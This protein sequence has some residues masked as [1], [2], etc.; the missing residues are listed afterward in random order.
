MNNALSSFSP[1]YREAREKFLAAAATAGLTVQSHL[2]PLNGRD[3]EALALDVVREG[4]MDAQHLLI[5][6]SGCHGV[7]GY[8]GSGVQVAAL[9]DTTWRRVAR[10][11]GVAV[12]Y[13]HAL[14]PYGF[15]HW[16]R[17]THE[18]VDL[19]RNFHDF[20]K[21]LPINTAYRDV[22]AL[23]LPALWPPTE[24]NQ[25]DVARYIAERGMAA[26]QAAI[27]G[28]QHE[29]ADGLFFGGT[30][31]TWSNLAVREVLRTHATT[32]ARIGW[33]DL[34]TGLGPSGHGERIYA[35]PN[36]A[37]S[38]ERARRW[39]DGDGR[40]PITSTYDG[41]SA[42]AP[43]T[44]IMWNCVYD[45]CPE[46][47]HT[48]IAM[49]Y[50][51]VPLMQVLQALR[52]EQWLQRNPEAPRE[53]HKAIKQQFLDAFYTDTDDWKQA[54]LRQAREAMLQAVQGLSE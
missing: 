40:T 31:P 27:T 3:G 35:G 5:I 19:N 45:E 52:A 26:F 46:S 49:E 9:G 24:E 43:L 13:L 12:L 42:S 14:N 47:Q 48:G 1:S 29:Y 21:P 54:I 17:V 32:A 25:Q 16:R 34:H 28:G 2:H 6:S 39:W 4:A 30:E 20:D 23:I 22:H 44:G 38:I 8:C 11:A 50:G 53:Q 15:S 33:I 37:A 10:E 41:S 51:T 7:E 18:N 36:N